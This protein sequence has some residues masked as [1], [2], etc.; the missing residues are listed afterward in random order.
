MYHRQRC[1]SLLGPGRHSTL[2]STE[3]TEIEVDMIMK[4]KGGSDGWGVR[5]MF[6]THMFAS[7]HHRGRPIIRFSLDGSVLCN[8][9]FIYWDTS[10]VAVCMQFVTMCCLAFFK[11]NL[12]IQTYILS[13]SPRIHRNGLN[14]TFLSLVGKFWRKDVYSIPH[15]WKKD[16]QRIF[17]MYI[18]MY[19]SFIYISISIYL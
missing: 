3:N 17:I 12:Y 2:C 14:V 19:I 6:E 8:I 13:G 1:E 7:S 15:F 11:I 10:V 18:Y 9:F 4:L 5:Y 16:I